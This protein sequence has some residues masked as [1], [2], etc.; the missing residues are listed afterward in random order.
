[1]LTE[2][3]ASGTFAGMVGGFLV[4]KIF[5]TIAAIFVYLYLFLAVPGSF[6]ISFSFITENPWATAVLVVAGAGALAL[7]VR[8]YWPRVL[9]LWEQAKEGGQILSHPGAYLGRVFLPEFIAWLANVGTV[10]IFLAAYAIP[11]TFHTVM[12]VVGG[13]GVANSVSVTPGGVGVQQ[14]FNVAALNSVTDSTTATAY[15]IAQQLVT[16]AWTI[17]MAIILMIWVF[18]WGGGKALFEESYAT[19]KDRVAEQKAAREAK[20]AAADLA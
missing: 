11:V 7:L 3:I 16:T 2:L 13:N 19:A 12:T 18:G 15:S 4:Q 6:D 8:H 10:A 14:A 1:M 20:R 9:K 5:F 17:L